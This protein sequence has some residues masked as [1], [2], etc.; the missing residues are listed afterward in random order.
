M[1]SRK[2]SS[3]LRKDSHLFAKDSHL[4]KKESKI[5]KRESGDFGE[6]FLDLEHVSVNVSL[7]LGLQRRE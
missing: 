1:T 2:G 7:V 5:V 4:F 6:P 3:G